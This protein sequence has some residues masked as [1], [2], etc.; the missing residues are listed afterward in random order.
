GRG[1]DQ[2]DWPDKRFPTAAAL[3]AVSAGHPVYL[4][5]VDG[6]AGWAN[7]KAMELAGITASTVD[8]TGGRILRGEGGAPSGVFVDRAQGLVTSKVPAAPREVRKR[9]LLRGLRAAAEAGLT[10]VHDAGVG[11]D[12][13]A[14]YKELLAE[15]TL[16][17]RVYV[18]IAMDEFLARGGGLRPEIGL[19][20]GRLTVRAIKVVSDGALGSRG[21]LLLAPYADEPGTRGLRTVDPAR[22]REVLRVAVMRGFQVNTHAIGDGANRLVL[23]PSEQ[24]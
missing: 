23:D 20:D 16:P 6:H 1:W 12:P 9:R 10:S 7:S 13:V 4:T 19:G 18:M 5:R 3:D 21:A 15:D 17:V 24:A 8:P 11:L 22:F 14:L 2:N